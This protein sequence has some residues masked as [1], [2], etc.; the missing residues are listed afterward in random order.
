V[1]KKILKLVST[2][3]S[4]DPQPVFSKDNRRLILDRRTKEQNFYTCQNILKG[5]LRKIL[6]QASA[7]SVEIANFSIS[8]IFMQFLLLFCKMFFNFTEI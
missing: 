6:K 2:I 7:V 3:F 1:E 4:P 8:N 5:V